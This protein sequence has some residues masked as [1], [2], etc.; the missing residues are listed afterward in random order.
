AV[1]HAQLSLKQTERQSGPAAQTAMARAAA[2]AQE[3]AEAPTILPARSFRYRALQLGATMDAALLSRSRQEAG[4]RG[5]AAALGLG[6]SPRMGM[7]S[8]PL[9]VAF[10]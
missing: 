1:S 8:A 10:P 4:A 5:A 9:F 3:A 6:A 2:L 7:L